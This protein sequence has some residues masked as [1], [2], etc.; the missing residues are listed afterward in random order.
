MST[1]RRPGRRPPRIISTVEALADYLDHSSSWLS[2]RLLKWEALG[3]PKR[4]DELDGWDIAAVDL[5]IDGRSKLLSPSDRLKLERAN[6]KGEFDL[7]PDKGPISR[8]KAA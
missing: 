1:P 7:G 4:D 8:K 6:L 2:A 5:W 3:F